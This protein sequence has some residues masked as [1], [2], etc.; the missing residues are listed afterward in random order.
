V[1]DACR[2]TFSKPFQNHFQHPCKSFS[3]IN[4]KQL[5]KV[6]ARKTAI[7]KTLARRK[8]RDR[9]HLAQQARLPKEVSG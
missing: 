1:R 7:K 8:N 9:K 2:K 4:K 6:F 5:G 3:V